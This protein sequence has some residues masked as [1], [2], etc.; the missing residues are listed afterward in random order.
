MEQQGWEHDLFFPTR[1]CVK[2]SGDPA[3]LSDLKSMFKEEKRF[4]REDYPDVADSENL[5]L[6]DQKY[7]VLKHVKDFMLSGMIDWLKAEGV[8]GE[9]TVKTHLFANYSKKGGFVPFH[10]HLSNVSG[11]FYVSVPDFNDKPLFFQGTHADYWRQDQGVLILHDPRFNASLAEHTS[12]QYA[13]FFPRPGMGIIFPSYLYHSVT[14]HFEDEDRVSLAIN[15]S[16][17]DNNDIPMPSDII[18]L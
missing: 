16:V 5:A 6:L 3:L 17:I 2:Q 13:K 7:P 14:P 10:N 15:F 8:E 9:F 11:V 18:K 12:K 4:L 1:V